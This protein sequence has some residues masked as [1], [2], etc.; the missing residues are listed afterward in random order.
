MAHES[1]MAS[2]SG[3][4]TVPEGMV[5]PSGFSVEIEPGLKFSF[6]LAARLAGTVVESKKS[7]GSALLL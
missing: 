5:E 6:I 7:L 4:G 3:C 1:I 2:E